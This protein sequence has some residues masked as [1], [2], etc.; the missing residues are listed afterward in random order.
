[1]MREQS[2]TDRL[3]GASVEGRLECLYRMAERYDEVDDKEINPSV[4]NLAAVSQRYQSP[5]LIAKGGMKRVFKVYDARA[6]RH[7]ALAMLRDDV[8]EDLRDP[9]IHEAW[10]VA[11][12][13]HPNIVTIHDVGVK[14]MD[15]P[16]F[17]MDLKKGESLRELVEKLHKGHSRVEVHYPLESLLQI[18]LKICDAIAYAHSLDI[19]HLDLKPANIQIGEYGEVLVY[20]WGLGRIMAGDDPQELDR[21]LF[22]PKLLGLTNVYGQFKGT[23]GYMAPEQWTEKGI[24]DKRTDVYGLGA[25]LYSLLTF[26]RPFS[27]SEKEIARKTMDGEVLPPNERMPER[28]IPVSLSAVVMKALR[29][30]PAQRYSSVN[31]LRLEVERYLMGL[32]TE[33]EEASVWKQLTLFYHRNKRFCLTLLSSVFLF[34]AGATVAFWNVSEARLAAESTLD[35]YEAGQSELERMSYANAESIVM[36]AQ[37]YHFQSDHNRAEATLL[38]ALEKNPSNHLLL[39]ELG[40]HYFILQ[41]FDEAITYLE[42]GLH[43]NDLICDLCTDLILIK[44]RD[45][46]LKV[47]QM[48]NLLSSLSSYRPLALRL[49]LHDQKH[50]FDLVERATIVEAYLRLINPEWKEGWFEYDALTGSLRMGGVGLT[51]L[52][53]Q[54]STL[55]GLHP[56]RLDL[57]GSEVED[58]WLEINT[59][60]E[61]LDIRNIPMN[62][63]WALHRFIHLKELVICPHQFSEDDLSLLPT[64]ITVLERD[65]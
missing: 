55:I 48:V 23:P 44:G 52:A 61:Y 37:R 50:R 1:M 30:D 39:R 11:Q 29:V 4:N 13:D 24:I 47:N 60:V 35:L 49:V 45:R 65:L 3:E 18:F 63:L 51:R 16:Y 40:I 41:Q 38:T 2:E 21:M 31:A 12:L 14:A 27:G 53:T 22:N 6:K 9:F 62:S 42:R 17:T 8:S 5:E 59:A 34:L 7:L 56:R 33:A 15:Q 25:I 54:Q 36:L 20:D 26:L 32:A 64:R 46:W 10:L 28:N 58:L 57:S 19:L 43:R